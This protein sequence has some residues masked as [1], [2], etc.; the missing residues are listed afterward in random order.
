MLTSLYE[1]PGTMNGERNPKREVKLQGDFPFFF[2]WVNFWVPFAVHFP[3][4]PFRTCE[5]MQN[6]LQQ[7]ML[8]L[9][10]DQDAFRAFGGV[11]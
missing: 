8:R 9:A 3:G 10:E 11:F 4:V 5:V 6:L 7:V 2:Y 1:K